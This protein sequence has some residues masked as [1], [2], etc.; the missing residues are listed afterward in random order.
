VLFHTILIYLSCLSLIRIIHSNVQVSVSN[1]QYEDLRSLCLKII[2]FSLNKYDGHEFDCDF[3]DTFF[4]SVK[5]LID[6]F[7]QK[8]SSSERP[9][10]LFSCFRAMSRSPT[11][12]SLLDREANLVPK[13][14]SILIVR[15]ASDAIISSV[16]NFIENLLILDTESNNQ[17]DDPIKR[18]FLPHL[19]V[20]IDCFHKLFQSRKEIHR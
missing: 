9:S 10:S 2:P 11:L 6:S 8:G 12:M 17:E 18:V 5:P 1:K 4:I 7:K 14:F 20:L 15:T 16:L 13:I 3:W 19:A